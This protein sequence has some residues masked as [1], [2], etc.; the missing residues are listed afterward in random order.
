LLA[1]LSEARSL[2][3][4][5]KPVLVGPVTYLALGKAQDDSDKLALLPRLLPVYQQLLAALAQ[6][7][8]EWV[9]LDEPVLVTELDAAWQAA[10]T[11][12]YAALQGAGPKILVATYF[13]RL[14][15]NLK[16][17]ASL[18]VDG[19]HLD[20]VN[21][22]AEVDSL[23]AALPESRVLSLGVVNG[24][25]IWRCDLSAILDR[26]EGYASTQTAA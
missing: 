1:Q 11:T 5:A 2:G 17:A 16:L 13:G 9:Q 7:G 19:I 26:L 22:G 21:A 12:A 25:N 15:E 6:A 24:R 4:A 20:V 23:L 18:P 3:F 10:L 8:A 14:G